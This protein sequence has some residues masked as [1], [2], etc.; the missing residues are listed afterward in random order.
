MRLFIAIAIP[1]EIKTALAAL[2]NDLRRAGAEV[3]WTRPENI[4]L[5]L[6]F[7]GEIAEQQS[8]ELAAACADTAVQFQPF[9]LS[10]NQPGVFPNARQP[11]VL[12]AG[13]AGEIETARQLQLQLEQRLSASGVARADKPFQPHL[14]IGRVKSGKNAR[15]LVALADLHELPALSFAVREIVLMKSELHPAGARYTALANAPLRADG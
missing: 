5:T 6:K 15:Q 4:H 10:L 2:Q 14:T 1:A 7:L 11:R 12:W 13:L 8:N 9:T 3:S